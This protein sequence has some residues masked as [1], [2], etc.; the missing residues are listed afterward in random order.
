MT[1]SLMRDLYNAENVSLFSMFCQ[2][3]ICRSLL[4]NVFSKMFKY[5][6]IVK[7][8]TLQST[9]DVDLHVKYGVF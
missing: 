6:K 5:E 4:A 2:K 1:I 8:K 3:V 7:G 9:F